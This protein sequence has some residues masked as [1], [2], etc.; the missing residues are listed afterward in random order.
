M[1]P[2]QIYKLLEDMENVDEN[3]PILE[4]AVNFWC[5]SFDI[6]EGYKH[7]LRL[8]LEDQYKNHAGEQDP[9]ALEKLKEILL[10]QAV[11]QFDEKA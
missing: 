8:C 2:E 9:K 5:S 6:C 7:A 3:L 4:N 10:G 11:M 1:K